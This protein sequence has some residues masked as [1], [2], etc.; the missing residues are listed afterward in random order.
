VSF[1]DNELHYRSRVALSSESPLGFL[2]IF[3]RFSAPLS[4]ASLL[5]RLSADDRPTHRLKR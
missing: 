5:S 1:L 4:P 2:S 3:P